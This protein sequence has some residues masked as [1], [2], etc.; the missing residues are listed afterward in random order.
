MMTWFCPPAKLVN[1]VP[2]AGLM[3]RLAANV[4]DTYSC[5]KGIEIKIMKI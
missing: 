1:Q 5:S 3:T 2:R 4:A